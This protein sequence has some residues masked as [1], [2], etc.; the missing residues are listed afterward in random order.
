MGTESF[1]HYGKMFRRFS[2][3]WKDCFHT[4]ENSTKNEIIRF[5]LNFHRRFLLPDF[6]VTEL[7]RICTRQHMSNR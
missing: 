4:V 7:I 3:Q 2:T 1:P 5:A 6:G